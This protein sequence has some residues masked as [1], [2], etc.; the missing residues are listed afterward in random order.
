MSATVSS[1]TV[2]ELRELM[3]AVVREELARKKHRKLPAQREENVSQEA[4]DKVRRRLRRQG[5]VA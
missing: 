1:L 5:V 4:M 3:R 2:A